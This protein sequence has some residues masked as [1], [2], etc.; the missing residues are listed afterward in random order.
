MDQLSEH[1]EEDEHIARLGSANVEAV[2]LSSGK[3]RC[4]PCHAEIDQ[5][6]WS[7]HSTS[8]SHALKVRYSRYKDAKAAAEADKGDVKVTPAGDLEFGLVEFAEFSSS[9]VDKQRVQPLVIEAHK[10]V[11]LEGARFK[12][13]IPGNPPRQ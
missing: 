4:K 7:R 2:Q 3:I 10:K 5:Q 6:D 9:T 11:T 13:K 8:A 12:E 1:L